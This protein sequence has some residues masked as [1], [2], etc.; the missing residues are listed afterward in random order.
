MLKLSRAVATWA[1]STGL[2]ADE[3]ILLLRAGWDE[4]VGGEVA[5]NS[6]PARIIGGTLQVITRSS[7]WSHQLT[8]LADHVLTAIAARLPRAGIERLRFRVGTLPAPATRPGAPSRR[9]AVPP[10]VSARPP[11]ASAREAIARFRSDVEGRRRT[12]RAAGWRECARCGALV[13]PR[14][15]RLCV[16]CQSAGLE[17]RAK[18]TARLLFEAPWLGFG[19]TAALVEG[20]QEREYESIRSQLLRR[21]WEMLARACAVK[22]LSRDG[23]ERLIASSYVVLRS[24]LPPEEIASATVRNIL[25]DELHDFLYDTPNT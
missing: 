23:R 12:A 8:F 18:A 15:D 16:P 4:M 6:Y 3:P 10:K 9:R 19:G 7:S 1:P 22:R 20:L 21:W 24:K 13:E 25:G 14:G 5:R 17:D 11:A 2:R